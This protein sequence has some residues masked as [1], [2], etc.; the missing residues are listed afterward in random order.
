MAICC[1]YVEYRLLCGTGL[2]TVEE[3]KESGCTQNGDAEGW[4]CHVHEA[5]SRL[6]A[7]QDRSRVRRACNRTFL[8]LPLQDYLVVT[9]PPS[10]FHSQRWWAASFTFFCIKCLHVQWE[11]WFCGIQQGGSSECHSVSLISVVFH[12]CCHKCHHHTQRGS[13]LSSFEFSNY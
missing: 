12:F 5:C 8:L 13:Y 10:S 6:W 11:L 1:T 7:A 9:A 4:N 2:C 3:E